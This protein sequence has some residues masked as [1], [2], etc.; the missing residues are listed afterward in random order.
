MFLPYRLL[1][2]ELKRSDGWKPFLQYQKSVVKRELNLCRIN[3][4]DSCKKSD[5]LPRFLRFRIP[6]NGCFDDKTVRDFQKK[7][8][9]QELVKARAHQKNVDD[10]VLQ[11]RELLKASAPY[12]TLP[13]IVLFV[14]KT[15]LESRR[16]QNHTHHKKLLQLSEDQER[17]LFTVKNTVITHNLDH[18][19]PR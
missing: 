6:N 7:L 14:R 3:F 1:A 15:L 11:K 17:P 16:T 19:P 12:K 5:L 13:S 9:H 10:V 18:E 4:L 2:L 8:L